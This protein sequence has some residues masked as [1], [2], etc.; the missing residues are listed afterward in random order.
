[1]RAARRSCRMRWRRAVLAQAR[2]ARADREGPGRPRRARRGPL[3]SR[4]SR[5]RLRLCGEHA[6][7]RT[8]ARGRGQD[9]AARARHH[10]RDG[11]R[12]AAQGRRLAARYVDSLGGKPQA[13]VIGTDPDLHRQCGARQ[14]HGGPWRRDRRFPSRRPLPS[15][16]RHRAG[17]ARDRRSSPAAAATTCCARSRS[18]TTSGRARSTRSASARSIPSATAPTAS[19]TTF[20][21]TAAAAAML[22]LDPTPGAPRASRSRPSRPPA[23]PIGSATA[24]MSRRRSISAAWARATASP[25]PPWSRRA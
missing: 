3:R 25:P 14:R 8:A 23:F 20:G 19:S 24:S 22:R 17:G 10:R 16:L 7:P 15:G 1:M 11:V 4:R 12:L 9:Q 21:A 2:H 5:W 13:T 18:A 6:R